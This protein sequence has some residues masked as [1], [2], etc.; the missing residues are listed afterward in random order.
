MRSLSSFAR[1]RTVWPCLGLVA[2]D[3]RIS[4]D[5]VVVHVAL[6]I[7][8]RLG[9]RKGMKKLEEQ[10]FLDVYDK[11]RKFEYHVVKNNVEEWLATDMHKVCLEIPEYCRVLNV[12][13]AADEIVPEQEAYEFDRRIRNS[14][15]HVIGGADHNFQLKQEE[16]ASMVVEFVRSSLKQPLRASL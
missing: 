5:D 4:D 9:G 13:G 15:V 1:R 8:M 2:V 12:H 6:G 10:G 11:T 14:S 16:L 7:S 3:V